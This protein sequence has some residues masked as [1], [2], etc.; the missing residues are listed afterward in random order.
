[1]NAETR[2]PN[3]LTVTVSGSFRRHIA[4]VQ[5]AV[6]SWREEG[7][8]VL[9]PADPRIVDAFGEFVFVSSDRRRTIK[10]VQ[11]RHFE[12]I[13]RS[14]LLWLVCPDGYV[15]QS[16][17]LEIG[18]AVAIGVPVFSDVAPSDWTIRQFV[19][20]VG[21]VNAAAAVMTGQTP[22]ETSEPSLLLAPEAAI[23]VAHGELDRIGSALSGETVYR[24]EDPIDGSVRRLRSILTVPGLR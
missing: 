3:S 18:Y 10:G 9:S 19:T 15:G 12:A 20:A 2:F 16:A 13:G 6:E 23:Q 5:D 11:G 7:A 14:D 22:L 21:S 17:A 4:G 8:E 1:M 24:G